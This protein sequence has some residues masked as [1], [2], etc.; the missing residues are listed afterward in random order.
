MAKKPEKSKK[1]AT[2]EGKSESK[3]ADC[4]FCKI[5]NGTIPSRK[6]YED[7]STIAILDINPASPG[8]ALV[9]PRQH[10]KTIMD[11]GQD[12]V[13][14]TFLTVKRVA[15]LVKNR[16]NC[17]G[18]NIMVNQGRE[19]GQ[20]IDHFHVHVVPRYKGDNIHIIPPDRKMSDEQLDEILEKLK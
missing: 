14:S 6:F 10:F 15:E 13:A 1:E 9:L 4:V 11:G 20:V 3:A 7:D 18:L 8:H 16:L 2:N 17:D 5:L 12:V 19:A